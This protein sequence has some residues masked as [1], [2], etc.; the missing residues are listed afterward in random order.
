MLECVEEVLG[1]VE[2]EPVCAALALFDSVAELHAAALR[3]AALVLVAM[4]LEVSLREIE[5]HSVK[6]SDPVASRVARAVGD[7]VVEVGETVAVREGDCVG[8]GERVALGTP[9]ALPLV[10][11]VA[12]GAAHMPVPALQAHP[13]THAAG[14]ANGTH[15]APCSCKGPLALAGHQLP[16]RAAAAARALAGALPRR[17]K[18]ESCAHTAALGPTQARLAGRHCQPLTH[19]T[20]AR[21][22]A[23]ALARLGPA[24]AAAS[25]LL[26]A[27]EAV[28]PRAAAGPR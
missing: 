19:S 8:K 21:G 3:L 25:Q 24:S 4:P 20:A 28:M 5:A 26:Q 15:C 22:W 6:L 10:L 14:A 17:R 7:G 18:A 27:G 23:A 12:V 16:L 13:A 9:V 2:E 11:A 1:V